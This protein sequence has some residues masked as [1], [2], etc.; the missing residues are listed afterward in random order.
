M[1]GR[2]WRNLK[3]LE[4]LHTSGG[5]VEQY[6][7]FRKQPGNSS[8]LKSYYPEISLLR[9]ITKISENTCTHKNGYRN[10]HSN[11]IHYSQKVE[12]TQI[13]CNRHLKSFNCH[14]PKVFF[15]YTGS[16]KIAI[17]DKE[18]KFLIKKTI[19]NIDFL[20]EWLTLL[21]LFD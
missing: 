14:K 6:S 19:Q 13:F 18:P 7:H 10:V 20:R 9:Y 2:I 1:L 16:S 8:K 11:I 21:V 15:L 4:F 17:S 12:T 5:K 3:E